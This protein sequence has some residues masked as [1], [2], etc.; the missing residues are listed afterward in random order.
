MAKVIDLTGK[1]FGS[2]VVV[3]LDTGH[4]GKGTRWI[5]QCDCGNYV[6]VFS[7]NIKRGLTRSC[8]CLRRN[9]LRKQKTTHGMSKTRLYMTW[10]NMIKRCYNKRCLSFKNYGARGITVCE[11]WKSFEPFY[12]WAVE[13]GYADDLTIDRIDVNGNYEPSN[14]RWATKKEQSN[15]KRSTHYLDYNGK[16]LTVSDLSKSTGIQK[17]TILWRENNW[18]GKDLDK[19]VAPKILTTITID[20]EDVSIKDG[21]KRYGIPISTIY[22][23]INAGYVGE[24]ILF[25]RVKEDQS[26]DT[27][28]KVAPRKQ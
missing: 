17:S 11:E 18:D 5:C 22:R 19:P 15:N 4:P 2:L 27:T 13:N 12:K 23:R 20:G 25:G 26:N 21:A 7:G 3:G 6:S 14:C 8:G 1:R 10:N 9:K 16:T 24:E 28:R